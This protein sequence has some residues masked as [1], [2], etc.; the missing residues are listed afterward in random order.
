MKRQLIDH[1]KDTYNPDS[2]VMEPYEVDGKPM[3]DCHAMFA[4]ETTT[5]HVCRMS[6]HLGSQGFLAVT[7]YHHDRMGLR[8]QMEAKES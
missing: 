6:D 4:P 5:D 1:I 3:L 8:W 7:T 2:I